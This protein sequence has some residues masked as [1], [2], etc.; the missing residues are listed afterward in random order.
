MTKNVKITINIKVARMMLGVAGFNPQRIAQMSD[1]EIF[2]K[3]LSMINCYGATSII[4]PL[5]TQ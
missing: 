4:E 3:V 1:D 5:K 2:A